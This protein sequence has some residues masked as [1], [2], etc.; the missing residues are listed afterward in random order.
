MVR[1]VDLADDSPFQ[2]SFCLMCR[3]NQLSSQLGNLIPLLLARCVST[4]AGDDASATGTLTEP[5]RATSSHG[6]LFYA[7]SQS[8]VATNTALRCLCE[9]VVITCRH[10]IPTAAA[11]ACD[12]WMVLQPDVVGS[13]SLQ[14]EPKTSLNRNVRALIHSRLC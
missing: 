3:W 10:T 7:A 4:A 1:S 13:V 14:F 11:P 12:A 5:Y 2:G 9:T 8:T 6:C